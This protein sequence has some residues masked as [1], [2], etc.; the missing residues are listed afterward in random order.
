[1]KFSLRTMLIGFGLFSIFL[2][3]LFSRSVIAVSLTTFVVAFVLLLSVPIALTTKK[4]RPFWIGFSILAV[5]SYWSSQ[6]FEIYNLAAE[7]LLNS[8]LQTAPI[9]S[10]P[11]NGFPAAVNVQQ[12]SLPPVA[13]LPSTTAYISSST[14]LPPLYSPYGFTASS[15]MNSNTMRSFLVVWG[16][17]LLGFVGGAVTQWYSANNNEKEESEPLPDTND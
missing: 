15:F 6:S 8:W 12:W 2:A 17:L 14:A 4:H 16:S 3:V 9:Q 13:V 5:G 11:V 1:M 7:Q 10:S